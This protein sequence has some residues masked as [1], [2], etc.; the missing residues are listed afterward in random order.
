M[1]VSESGERSE[2]EEWRTSETFLSD[3]YSED[4]LRYDRA[5][6]RFARARYEALFEQIYRRLS[7]YPDVE[8]VAGEVVN[9]VLL[10]LHKEVWERRSR[11]PKGI[12]FRSFVHQL[13]K[14]VVVDVRR[15]LARLREKPVDL[16]DAVWESLSED[17]AESVDDFVLRD[18]LESVER[19]VGREF[20]SEHWA[21]WDRWKEQ[22]G[23]RPEGLAREVMVEGTEE[24]NT[25]STAPEML[26]IGDKERQIRCRIRKRLREVAVQEI[27]RRGW[28]LREF[29]G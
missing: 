19:R 1:A 14:Y 2:D 16:R 5:F 15:N 3:I 29:L 23:L 22:E 27:T 17:I 26:P 20:S 13:A 24:V 4:K 6:E 10:R 11:H 21:A 8:T 28:D 9:D 7:G 12:T 25:G 18:L